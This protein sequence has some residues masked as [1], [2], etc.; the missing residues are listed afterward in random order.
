[1]ER[2]ISRAQVQETMSSIIEN[3]K[4]EA[5]SKTYAEEEIMK[6]AK[7]SEKES[8]CES[9]IKSKGYEDVVVYINE[10]KANVI[11]KC[12]TLSSEDATKIA[13]I[14]TEQTGV[15]PQGIKITAAE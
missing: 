13:E 14:V 3:E 9:L 1:M 4:S 10:D 7:L 2:E 15:S 8:V 5:A 12:S 11:V 6:V